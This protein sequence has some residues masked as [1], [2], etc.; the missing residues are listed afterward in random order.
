MLS[1]CRAVSIW[2]CGNQSL[3]TELR[4]RTVCEIVLNEQFYLQPSMISILDPDETVLSR[5]AL[6]ATAGSYDNARAILASDPCINMDLATLILHE[7]CLQTTKDGVYSCMWHV[8]GLASVLKRPIISIYPDFNRRYRA[9]FNRE[10]NPRILERSRTEA[11]V[12]I[13]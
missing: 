3:H 8:H 12:M 10:C 11:Q 5:N 1:S 4:V 6:P 13:M 2:C 9:L 7:E